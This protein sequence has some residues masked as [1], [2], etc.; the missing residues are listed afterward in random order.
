MLRAAGRPERAAATVIVAGTNGKGSTSAAIASILTTAGYRTGFYSSPH[1]VELRE[2]WQIDG[3]NIDERTFIDSVHELQTVATKSGVTPTYF[4]ALTLLAFLIFRRAGCEVVVLEV[5]MGG[6]LDAT[7]VTRP[8][9]AVITSVGIDHTEYLGTTI[10]SIAREKAGVIHRGAIA[11]TSNSEKAIVKTIARRAAKLDVTLHTT[12]ADSRTTEVKESIDGISFVLATPHARY[13]IDSPLAGAH[14]V[15]NLTLAVRTAEE[16]RAR[17]PRIDRS[18]IERGIATM[19][20]RGRLERFRIGGRDVF[21]DGAHNAHAARR[22]VEFVERHLA[23]PRTLVFGVLRDKDVES[24]TDVLFP[25]FDRLALTRPE[26]ERAADPEMLAHLARKGTARV[27]IFPRIE[28]A[29]DAALTGTG[30]VVIAGS[31]YLAG[32][33]VAVLE[34]RLHS[35]SIG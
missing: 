6:R 33:A 28:E 11:L 34:R 7:N 2:R 14:Q 5:G 32:S 8:L 21:V 16:L 9:A 23:R 12:S 27:E 4:E 22:L 35:A 24:I 30:S 29:I 31:L 13:R 15:E 10:R 1:L 3:V 19:R 17:F 20:W 18:A 25:C 26:S